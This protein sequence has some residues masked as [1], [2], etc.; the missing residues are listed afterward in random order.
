MD[1]VKCKS[2][3]ASVTYGGIMVERC[4][5]CKGI[6]FDMLEQEDLKKIKGSESIDVGDPAAGRRMNEAEPYLCQR[7]GGKMIRMVDPEQP[8]IWYESCSGCYGVFFD[9]GEFKD[10]KEKTAA[11]FFRRLTARER[12]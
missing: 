7:C 9:A 1:C 11:D 2:L 8:H 12:K 5:G 3:M 10:F 4:A 6:W